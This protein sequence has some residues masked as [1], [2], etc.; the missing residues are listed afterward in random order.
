MNQAILKDNKLLE[1]KLDI[2]K[3]QIAFLNDFSMDVNKLG[4]KE[5]ICKLLCR[6]VKDF[7]GKGYVLVA[8]FDYGKQV[9]RVTAAEGF[10][11]KNIINYAIKILKTNPFYADFY[12]E[13]ISKEDL[14]LYRS[15]RLSL[16]E[17][18]L[19]TIMA[20]RFPKMV[21]NILE[22]LL[23]IDFVFS[24]GFTYRDNDIGAMFILSDTMEK[25]EKNREV[26]EIMMK[27]SSAIISKINSEDLLIKSRKKIEGA[28]DSTI[29]ALSSM[30]EQKDPYT[31]GHQQRVSRLSVALANELGLNKKEIK[32]IAIA[33]M[34]HDIGKIVIPTSILSKPTPLTDIEFKIIKNHPAA[35][36]EIINKVEFDY[37][38]AEVMLQHHE[39]LDGSGYPS[40]LKAD[41]IHYGSKILAVADVVEAMTS[42][43]PY[44][45]SLGIEKTVD[46]LKNNKGILYDEDIVK[47]CIKILEEKGID[48]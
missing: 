43:R 29:K 38:V 32:G 47:S 15:G 19:Y 9:S 8:L 34:I 22:N 6:E 7:I 11:D 27:H 45:P 28:L 46:E 16:M 13:D 4:S 37:P 24:I 10:E 14:D 42:H 31:Y 41:K 33:S 25:I 18:G 1:R 48:F 40:G 35:G 26:L 17:G 2:K 39:R 3:T 21:C 20:K 12:L 23:G 36:Y 5:D 44:R 30:L